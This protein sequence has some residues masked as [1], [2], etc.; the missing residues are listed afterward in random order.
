MPIQAWIVLREYYAKERV[1][2]RYEKKLGDRIKDIRIRFR[3]FFGIEENPFYRFANGR[4]EPKFTVEYQ[5]PSAGQ[6]NPPQFV[7]FDDNREYPD[8]NNNNFDEEDDPA[9]RFLR[10]KKS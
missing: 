4:W 3:A 6:D 9:D 5:T 10:N 1:L 8:S 7:P 2:R